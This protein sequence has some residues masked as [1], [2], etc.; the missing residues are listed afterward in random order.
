[1]SGLLDTL[2]GSGDPAVDPNT[3]MNDAQRRQV[4]FGGISQIGA[5]LLAAGQPM[6]PS[7]RA[8]Y[9]AQLGQ[10][11]QQMQQ[12]EAGY[13]QQATRAMQ[14]RLMGQ[15][16]QK[17]QRENLANDALLKQ[18]NTPEFLAQFDKLPPPLRAMATLSISK[19]DVPTAVKVLN[20]Y[21]A[22]QKADAQTSIA[23][24]RADIADKREQNRLIPLGNGTAID[25]VTHQIIT[26]SPI[27]GNTVTPL[28]GYPQPGAAPPAQP[29]PGGPAPVVPQPGPAPVVPQPA[30]PVGDGGP[31]NQPADMST[32]GVPPA[33][34][35]A[36]VL[37]PQQAQLVTP[38]QTAA[39]QQTAAP[40]QPYVFNPADVDAK[41]RNQKYL[42]SLPDR[43]KTLVQGLIEG[44]T[45]IGRGSGI[46]T[47]MTP[48][49]EAA[50][51]VAQRGWTPQLYQ[52]MLKTRLDYGS[53]GASG[54]QGL[55]LNT[56]IGHVGEIVP[57]ANKLHNLNIPNLNSLQNAADTATG[58]AEYTNLQR[59]INVAQTELS[60]F[61]K[62]S[63][64]ADA[65]LLRNI[66]ELNA[67][68]SPEQL[69]GQVDVIMK[70]MGERE[71]ALN[72][73]YE[74]NMQG[75]TLDPPLISPHA[76]K[77]MGDV[78]AN[79]IKGSG[80]YKAQQKALAGV[81]PEAVAALK[82]APTPEN[83]KYFDEH[84]PGMSSKVLGQ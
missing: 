28:P 61:L 15:Q 19:G 51:Q 23:N 38:P 54:K 63:S 40:R 18:A 6:D 26:T 20:D 29:Q 48:E 73:G 25:P 21:V 47:N 60:K 65:E 81:P 45:T 82:A 83:R 2:F 57:L 62:G 72:Y 39:P 66:T 14:Q 64:P 31:T 12:Q 84:W 10:V 44:R 78:A 68:M 55:F 37:T 67:N 80:R 7:Q 76:R 30:V 27:F 74:R 3:G 43:A 9:L 71:Q 75:E 46:P 1:M 13:Q 53:A 77:I 58:K 49:L 59:Q 41:G 36:P 50:A 69:Q 34:L 33:A 56:T 4:L 42:D 32:L 16:F 52:Q 70:A 24:R 5:S 79:P 17:E 22:Q 11:P 35:Q 8:P